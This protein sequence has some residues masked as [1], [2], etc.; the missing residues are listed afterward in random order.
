[1]EDSEFTAGVTAGLVAAEHWRVVSSIIPVEASAVPR[2]GRVA[3]HAHPHQELL[4]PLSGTSVYGHGDAAY[5]CSAGM[6]FFFDRFEP[7]DDGYG[8]ETRDA[9]HLWISIVEDRAFAR[10]LRVTDGRMI[11]GRLNRAVRPED[12]GM[13][14]QRAIGDARRIAA[15]SQGLARARLIGAVAAI[16]GLI[17]EPPPAAAADGTLQ[18]LAIEAIKRHIAHTAGNGVT[19]AHLARI[20]GFS[21]FHFLRLFKR[22]TGMTVHRYVDECR[23]QSVAQM[24][25]D[26]RSDKEIGARLGFSCPAAFSR[27]RKGKR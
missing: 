26:G 11:P 23:L 12:V 2:R 14:L 6:V 20:A 5:P 1:M 18:E 25:A 24:R 17:V 10:T 15:T 22:H 7:H 8:I 21:K 9:L 27:W 3:S 19:L 4:V 13:D 16:V